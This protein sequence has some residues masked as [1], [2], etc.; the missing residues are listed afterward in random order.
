MQY[1][2]TYTKPIRL[3]LRTIT[4]EGA[5]MTQHNSPRSGDK[6]GS[7]HANPGQGSQDKHSTHQDQKS[8]HSQNTRDSQRQGQSRHN[9]GRPNK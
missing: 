6:H 1:F 2:K 7:Q 9:E 8:S 5:K 4:L 3:H